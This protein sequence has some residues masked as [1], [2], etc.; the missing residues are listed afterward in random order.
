MALEDGEVAGIRE[1][2]GLLV[3]DIMEVVE[4]MWRRSRRR[5][6][7]AGRARARTHDSSSSVLEVPEALKLELGT[8]NAQAIRTYT[9]LKCKISQRGKPHLDHKRII[10][11]GIPDFW[12]SYYEPPVYVGHDW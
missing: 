2:L 10:I 9:Q 7:R 1:E 12:V 5:S 4:V 3:E 8:V 11:H 6:P